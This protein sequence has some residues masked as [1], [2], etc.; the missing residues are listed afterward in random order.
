MI[1]QAISGLI[2]EYVDAIM[3]TMLK[4][5][6]AFPAVKAFPTALSAALM[7]IHALNAKDRTSYS[8]INAFAT[9]E[10]GLMTRCARTAL[11]GA[12]IVITTMTAINAKK[13]T[14]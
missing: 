11:R 12:Q 8:P 6:N 7:E 13:D 10:N 14:I 3:A 4:I 9:R 5:K 2:M 1:L